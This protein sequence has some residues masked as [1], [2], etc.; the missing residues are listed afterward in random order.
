[1]YLLLLILA[2]VNK[3]MTLTI[4]YNCLN[5]S[6]FLNLEY[7]EEALNLVCD[8]TNTQLS[9]NMWKILELIYSVCKTSYI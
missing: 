1:M 2:L 7:Y 3:L 9:P 5:I 6:F 4:K 8:L